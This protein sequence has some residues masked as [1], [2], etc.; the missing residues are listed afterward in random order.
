MDAIEIVY[1]TPSQITIRSKA[2]AATISGEALTR[3]PGEPDFI[4]HA[5]SLKFWLTRNGKLNIPIDERN[6]I[7]QEV[8]TTLSNRGWRIDVEE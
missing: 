7:I 4:L 6:R 5:G 2:K 3:R 8:S 1:S